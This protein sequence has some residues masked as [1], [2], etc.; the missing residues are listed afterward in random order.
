MTQILP[1]DIKDTEK[2]RGTL[3]RLKTLLRIFCLAFKCKNPQIGLFF[4]KQLTHSQINLSLGWKD[5]QMPVHFLL[6]IL[7]NLASIVSFVQDGPRGLRKGRMCCWGILSFWC[8]SGLPPLTRL[9]LVYF[10]YLRSN[11]VSYTSGTITFHI[12]CN[13]NKFLLQ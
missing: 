9:E 4:V 11:S 3:R 7:M 1:E 12:C 13:Q 10:V 5:R 8:G 6:E 2:F